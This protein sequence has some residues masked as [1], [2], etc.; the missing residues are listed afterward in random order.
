MKL[1]RQ[2]RKRVIIRRTSS[3]ASGRHSKVE[4]LTFSTRSRFGAGL[5]LTFSIDFAVFFSIS[6]I[7]VLVEGVA[8]I[9]GVPFTGIFAFCCFIVVISVC[10]LI[11]RPH[12]ILIAATIH[13]FA[14]VEPS[15]MQ[16]PG[17][18][19]V[20]LTA[21]D[22]TVPGGQLY[23]SA[24]AT[25]ST[26]GQLGL[27]AAAAL[28]NGIALSETK[29]PNTAPQQASTGNNR[30]RTFADVFAPRATLPLLERPKP[31]LPPPA[32]NPNSSPFYDSYEAAV[33]SGI[34]QGER[35]GYL[36]TPVPSGHWLQYGQTYPPIRRHKQTRVDHSSTVTSRPF[37]NTAREDDA[38][39]NR[40]FSSF[41]PSFE[42][43]GATVPV[44]VKNQVWW[45]EYGERYLKRILARAHPRADKLPV[46]PELEEFPKST[47][48]NTDNLTFDA[49]NPPEDSSKNKIEKTDQTTDDILVNISE[50]LETLDSYRRIRTAQSPSQSPAPGSSVDPSAPSAPEQETYE[51]L[52]TML[53]TIV[54]T[55]PPYLVS[56]LNGDQLSR[57]NINQNIVIESPDYPG[58]MEE[59]DFTIQKRQAAKLRQAQSQAQAQTTTARPSGRIMGY[60]TPP[61]YQRAYVQP[62]P[63]RLMKPMPSPAQQTPTQQANYQHPRSMYYKV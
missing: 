22:N 5:V 4:F 16:Q 61:T 45:D 55:L 36:F 1:D 23:S 38:S 60:Q 6:R 2:P 42:S 59:D 18:S 9:S 44:S 46:S 27:S 14:L 17:E 24:K 62:A 32:R 34:P 50:L 11:I 7:S 63:A 37:I 31:P 35:S 33:S 10:I 21:V 53:V 54:A 12:Y 41:A 25:T 30:K 48:S 29:P 39:F 40:A 51:M 57:L 28:P 19:T 8:E 49:P 13:I 43:A 20:C 3:N 47:Q 52:R 56:K 26:G 58:T 15:N